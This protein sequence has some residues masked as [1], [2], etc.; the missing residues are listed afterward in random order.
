M[1]NKRFGVQPTDDGDF[2]VTSL[3]PSIEPEEY[4]IFCS[5]SEI[6]DVLRNI[7]D[8][9][10]EDFQDFCENHEYGDCEEL[11]RY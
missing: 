2:I 8:F 7:S 11:S 3:S 5:A 10:D 1:A 6:I 4:N 9:D